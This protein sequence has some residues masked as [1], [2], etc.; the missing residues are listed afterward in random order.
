MDKLKCA[1]GHEF[2]SA[3]ALFVGYQ[4]IT[5]GDWVTVYQCPSCMSTVGGPEIHD[6]CRCTGCEEMIHGDM[7]DPKVL[8]ETGNGPMQAYCADCAPRHALPGF[9]R[10]AS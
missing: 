7:S 4:E 2:Q 3:L 6:A 1:A 5:H 10:V 8:V 9:Q